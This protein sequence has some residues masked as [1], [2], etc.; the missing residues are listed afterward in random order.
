MLV[1]DLYSNDSGFLGDF[2]RD[3]SA[4][5]GDYAR[6]SCRIQRFSLIQT[7]L[8]DSLEAPPDLCIVD[9]RDDPDRALDFVGQLRKNAGT[10][11]MVIAPG[12][13]WAMAA[14]DADVMSYLLDPPDMDRAGEIILRRFAQRFQ[15]QEVQFPFRTA[16]GLQ[17]IS[18]DHIVYVEYSGHRMIV[19]TDLDKNVETT[20]M[21]SSFGEATAA[22][23]KDPRFVRTHASFL[24]NIMHVLQFEQFCLRMDTGASVPISHAKKPLVKK[25]IN[26][27]FARQGRQ[28]APGLWGNT[29]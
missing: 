6:E 12:P 17:L 9:L 29:K 27:F 14:Y 5:L 18:A 19:H 7:S 13:Q 11:V 8:Y 1:I 28:D 26:D 3:L 16:S 20:T 15:A 4:R 23:L 2:A 24:V 21:R 22:L 25:H 10:E